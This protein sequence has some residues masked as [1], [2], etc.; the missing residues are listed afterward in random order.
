MTIGHSVKSTALPVGPKSISW[1]VHS[2][3]AWGQVCETTHWHAPQMAIGGVV[4]LRPLVRHTRL[5]SR[6]LVSLEGR[7]RIPQGGGGGLGLGTTSAGE[8]SPRGNFVTPPILLQGHQTPEW[9]VS[10]GENFVTPPTLGSL[11]TTSCVQL[12]LVQ[13][14][15]ITNSTETKKRA[16]P[17]LALRTEGGTS[18]RKRCDEGRVSSGLKVKHAAGLG[19]QCYIR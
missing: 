14:L 1:A 18:S 16:R 17:R 2:W 15:N 3:A 19:Q 11:W 7:A 13:I 9:K 5:G 4:A 6:G 12:W 10:L 8:N